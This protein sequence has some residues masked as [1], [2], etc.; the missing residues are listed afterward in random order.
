[1]VVEQL[2]AVIE[3]IPPTAAKTGA[4]GNEAITNAVAEAAAGFSFPLVVDPVMISKHGSPLLSEEAR[5]ALKERLLPHC[6]LVTPNLHEAEALA[7]MPVRTLADMR[8]AAKRICDLGAQAA[9]VKGG[10]SEGDATDVLFTDGY[11]YEYSAERV[12]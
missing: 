2:E 11:W 10:H 7:G 4:L 12:D 9:L 8:D 5:K 1:M 3:D 6:A